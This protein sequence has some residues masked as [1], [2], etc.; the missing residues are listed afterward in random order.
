EESLFAAALQLPTPTAR[1]G[2]LDEACAEEPTLRRR[3]DELLAFHDR[4]EGILD[5]TEKFP[6]AGLA[7]SPAEAPIAEGPG[8]SI[9]PYVLQERIGAGGFGLVFAAEQQDPV[10]RTVAL[11]IIKPGMDTR[12][13]IQRFAAER[14]ALAIMDHPNIARV[15]DAGATASGRPYFAMELV[16]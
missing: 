2:F 14:Q 7:T 6:Q 1:A 9:G 8:D 10:R 5:H 16:R 11:K 4:V 15:F 12:E 3:L 13:V